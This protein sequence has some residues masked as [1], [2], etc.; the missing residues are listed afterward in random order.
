MRSPATERAPP[1]DDGMATKGS[2]ARQKTCIRNVATYY[3]HRRGGADAQ[4]GENK[5]MTITSVPPVQV[6][7]WR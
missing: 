2:Y 1:R 3:D 5:R 7:R 4:V 6:D